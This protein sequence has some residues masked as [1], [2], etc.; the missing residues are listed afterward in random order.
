MCQQGITELRTN[1]KEHAE[2]L[3]FDLASFTESSGQ[4]RPAAPA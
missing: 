4:A 2:A 1:A 3:A